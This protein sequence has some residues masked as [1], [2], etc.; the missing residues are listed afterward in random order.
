MEQAQ[1]AQAPLDPVVNTGATGAPAPPALAAAA[2]NPDAAKLL[3][4]TSQMD[5]ELQL[6]RKK[7]ADAEAKS[8]QK[9]AFI[10]RTEKKYEE[11]NKPK[12]EEFIKDRN[13]DDAKK[14]ELYDIFT[15][16]QNEEAFKLLYD[17]HLQK[18]S[19]AASAAELQRK[20]E[21]AEKQLKLKED[22]ATQ[23]KTTIEQVSNNA[24]RD[25]VNTV[26][27]PPAP[28]QKIAVAASN[29]S[30]L[31][32]GFKGLMKPYPAP[33][34]QEMEELSKEYN[35]LNPGQV[36]ASGEM[37]RQLPTHYQ[38]PELPE[39][40]ADPLRP[41]HSLIGGMRE[42]CEGVFAALLNMRGDPSYS[43]SIAPLVPDK[44][45]REERIFGLKK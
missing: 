27:D 20:L 18:I 42:R 8:A 32:E 33:S 29:D 43:A 3:Q 15:K 44:F 10:Q 22:Q 45:E 1:Q 14:K 5:G 13:F 2:Q 38:A 40:I 34:K 11:E 24:R 7:L 41:G 28:T 21:E 9:D 39:Q 6:L 26:I 31:L 12:Y 25:I 4:V 23:L 19:V 37:G 36:A 17:G 30:P 35:F 16:P